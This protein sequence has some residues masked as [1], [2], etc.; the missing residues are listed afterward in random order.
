[1]ARITQRGSNGPTD[2]PLPNSGERVMTPPSRSVYHSEPKGISPQEQGQRRRM[3][4]QRSAWEASPTGQARTQGFSEGM[5]K[6]ASPAQ[7][8]MIHNQDR[9]EPKG[10]RVYDRQLPGM[11]DPDAAP[12]PPKWEELSHENQQH[13][14]RGL[15]RQGTDIGTMTRD[16]GAQMDQA[17]MRAHTA[18]QR[19]YAEDFYEKGEPR[20]KIDQSAKEL[21][22][23]VAL[24]AQ[25]NAFTSPNTKFSQRGAD[26]EMKFPNDDAARHATVHVQ[27]GGDPAS[28]TT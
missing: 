14:I 24:H 10:P 5:L 17:S 6:Q 21:G 20:Q 2:Q 12:R 13:A 8:H 23:P 15:A 4:N 9:P 22:V 26:G 16:I 27:R 11:S 19:P 18:G 28:I 25:T 7:I 3:K 1:M